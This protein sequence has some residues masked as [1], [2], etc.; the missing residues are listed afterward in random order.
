MRSPSALILHNWQSNFLEKFVKKKALWKGCI[1]LVRSQNAQGVKIRTGQMSVW[2][3]GIKR[4]CLLATVLTSENTIDTSA[5]TGDTFYPFWQ[6]HTDD[7]HLWPRSQPPFPPDQIF[8]TMNIVQEKSR[9]NIYLPIYS[10][11]TFVPWPSLPMSLASVFSSHKPSLTQLRKRFS[12]K[13]ES[14]PCQ[15]LCWWRSLIGCVITD[16]G[17]RRGWI[18]PPGAAKIPVS[19]HLMTL[20]QKTRQFVLWHTLRLKALVQKIEWDI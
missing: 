5:A 10:C 7:W 18:R 19:D 15:F 16:N 8:L 6:P 2:F 3:K 12:R 4:I 20:G 13:L 14:I 17:S 11:K 9:L 1:I